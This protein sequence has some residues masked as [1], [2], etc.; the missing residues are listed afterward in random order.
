M[1]RFAPFVLFLFAAILAAAPA[2]AAFH[3]MKIVEVF[4][5]TE[6]APTAQY[7]QLQMYAAGQHLVNGH[8]VHVFDSTGGLVST[9]TFGGSLT[10]SANQTKILVGTAAVPGFFGTTVDLVMP[11][12]T[13]SLAGGKVCFDT[14]D[15]MAWGNYSGSPSH[16]CWRWS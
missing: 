11:S 2:R 7:V 15:C 1:K 8:S 12:G 13:I 6:A 14:I 16:A 3:L 4:P 5:G 10:N 9:S